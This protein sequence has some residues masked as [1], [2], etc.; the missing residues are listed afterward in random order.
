M[1]NYNQKLFSGGLRG[2]LHQWRFEW[3][4]RH[5][6]APEN[7]YSLFELGCFDCRSLRFLPQPQRY[8][9]ADAGWEGGLNDAQMSYINAPWVQLVMAHSAHDLAPY[10]AQR[11]DYS[12]ALETLEHIPDGV[13][14]GYLEFLATV[15]TKKLLISVP[16]EVGPVFLAKHFAKKLLPHLENGETDAY[17]LKEVYWATR[18]DVSK[19]RRYEHKGFDYRKLVAMLGEYFD[20]TQV[21]GIP[22]ARHPHLSFQVGI[23]AQPKRTVHSEI[24]APL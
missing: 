16:V 22:F 18:G 21:E 17:T 3:L 19:V 9:G 20:V 15:T 23:V 14:R 24:L 13:L 12:I 7:T 11:F 8:L 1:S 4:K 2:R 10:A 6:I 5:L